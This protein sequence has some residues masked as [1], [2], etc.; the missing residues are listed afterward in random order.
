MEAE[1]LGMSRK[2]ND[3]AV[4]S[5]CMVGC[6][7]WLV[8]GELPQCVCVCVCVCVVNSCGAW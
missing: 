7:V 2:G 1:K 8:C 4:A 3:A 6:G 5:E